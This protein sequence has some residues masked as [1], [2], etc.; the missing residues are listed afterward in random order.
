MIET[1][2]PVV[3]KCIEN[4]SDTEGASNLLYGFVNYTIQQDLEKGVA[5]IQFQYGD[6][7][8]NKIDEDIMLRLGQI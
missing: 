6:T 8:G 2:D 4:F 7:L 1:N 5:N 3:V